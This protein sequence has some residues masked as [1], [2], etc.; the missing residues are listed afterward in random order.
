MSE[1]PLLAVEHLTTGF[2]VDGRFV[3]A[4]I[5]VSFAV[6]AGETLGLV[7]ESGSGKSLTAF[8]IMR[9]VRA[10]RSDRSGPRDLQGTRPARA[11][12]ARDAG[13]ARWRDRADLPG[14]DDGAESRLHHRESDSRRRCGSTGAPR[15]EPRGRGPSS[16]SKPSASP[17]RAAHPRVPAPALR[18]PAA[19]GADRDVAGVRSV[20][21]DRRRADDGARRHHP[22]AD[23]RPAARRC[24]AGWASRCC[25]S[26][27]TSESSR[28]WPIASPSCTPAGSSRRRRSRRSFADPKHPYT[29]GLMA[30]MPGGAPG[31]R[32]RAI[33]G[34]VP[35]LGQLPPGCSFTPRCPDRFEPCPTAHPGIRT[36]VRPGR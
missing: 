22:G 32:L 28:R 26:P 35:P 2:D 13:R 29:R 14:T 12:R 15:A 20:A 8:S 17:S 36:S 21:G 3:P 16:C 9:L 1:G 34:T 25:S 23:P 27:T 33:Q 10:A 11:R 7:G 30:S 31:T 19:A 6:S 18:R 24:S 4:V 5:D